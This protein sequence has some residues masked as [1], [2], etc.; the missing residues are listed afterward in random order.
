MKALGGKLPSL[1]IASADRFGGSLG[2]PF[3][4]EA[5]RLAR[6]LAR[7]RVRVA[8]IL[9]AALAYWLGAVGTNPPA[10]LSS[11]EFETANP[12]ERA[13][14]ET[15]L[16]SYLSVHL[17]RQVRARLRG[18]TLPRKE[19]QAKPQGLTPRAPPTPAG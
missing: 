11:A 18:T 15:T 10:A 9:R 7:A 17:A 16:R 8:A 4:F 3:L 12:R 19:I 5:Y 6:K 13:N 1:D 14:A 2:L